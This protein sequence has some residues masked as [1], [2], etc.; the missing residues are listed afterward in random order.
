MSQSFEILNDEAVDFYRREGVVCLRG[1][2]TPEW[3]EAS[4]VG[5]QKSI[6]NPGRF[7]RDYTGDG[8]VSRSLRTE[9]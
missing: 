5:M 8:S 1:A 7:F 6:D 2:I 4:R 9:V 3:L